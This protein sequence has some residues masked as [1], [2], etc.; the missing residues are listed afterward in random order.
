MGF[1]WPAPLKTVQEEHGMK[2]IA[3]NEAQ[4]QRWPILE[5]LDVEELPR[6]V[7]L[8][9]EVCVVGTR[10]EVNLRLSSPQVSR[11]HAIFV[12]DRDSIYLRDLASLNHTYVNDAPAREAVLHDGDVI[13]LGPL[14]FRCKC[15]F[16]RPADGSDVHAP[17]AE[18]LAAND[19]THVQLTGRRS[20]LIGSR[21][22]CDVV[23][24]GRGVEPS[25]AI[26]FEHD[27]RRYIRDLRSVCGTWV[28]DNAVGQIELNDGDEIRIAQTEFAYQH[29]AEAPLPADEATE[30]P[31]ADDALAEDPD[32]LVQL[33]LT[34]DT[35]MSPESLA[36]PEDS[37]DS[38]VIP[39]EPAPAA[40]PA[41][42]AAPE[43]DVLS[44]RLA[45]L[46]DLDAAAPA[47][48]ETPAPSHREAEPRGVSIESARDINASFAAH[49]GQRE[50]RP[51]E[52]KSTER[53]DNA[54]RSTV[55]RAKP[56]ARQPS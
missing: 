28:N 12:A 13:G 27:G 16:D 24:P 40:A 2:Q 5:P 43:L 45:D 8:N 29:V 25:H 6:P 51:R 49:P 52:P 14:S 18:L 23:L 11:T 30:L 17:P 32:D 3:M 39:L 36:A 21:D 37:F 55:E 31:L 26:I 4:S 35:A 50:R 7:A 20:V 15:G 33:E 9:Q 44:V 19:G 53:P 56:G 42:T 1:A 41:T 22:D 46:N 54:P 47:A 34:D 48:D 10:P 38:A